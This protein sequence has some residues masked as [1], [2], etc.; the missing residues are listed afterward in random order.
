MA[1]PPPAADA[2]SAG[3]VDAAAGDSSRGRCTA[4]MAGAPPPALLQPR[5]SAGAGAAA[6]AC[7]W[8]CSCWAEF[9]RGRRGGLR[10]RM[11]CG[12]HRITDVLPWPPPL[13]R[14]LASHPP[15]NASF[16]KFSPAIGCPLEGP[17]FAPPRFAC[18]CCSRPPALALRRDKVS[19]IRSAGLLCL[20]CVTRRSFDVPLPIPLARTF[21]STRTILRLPDAP[22][23]GRSVP[24]LP[25]AVL[26]LGGIPPPPRLP[27]AGDTGAGGGAPAIRAVHRP[28]LLSPAA[29]STAPALAASAAGGGG[30]VAAVFL[31]PPRCA[32]AAVF[33]FP[34]CCADAAVFLFRPRRGVRLAAPLFTSHALGVHSEADSQPCHR[35]REGS[36]AFRLQYDKLHALDQVRSCRLL[37]HCA[38][39]AALHSIVSGAV[40][41]SGS[42]STPP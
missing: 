2:A 39:V 34:P 13:S 33:L 29:A 17:I 4:R 1:P 6:S 28:L 5:N 40:D 8:Q 3:A 20:P 16:H 10:I 26:V 22:T 25:V 12:R 11:L 19:E 24:R 18:R 37:R 41:P 32:I 31:F 35:D 42:I 15:Y 30:A 9:R 36:R 21:G 7:Q 27:V 38:R 14:S 23:G